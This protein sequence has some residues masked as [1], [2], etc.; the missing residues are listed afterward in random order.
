MFII[1]KTL[2][3]DEI[4]ACKDIMHSILLEH[5]CITCKMDSVWNATCEKADDKNLVNMFDSLCALTYTP[6]EDDREDDYIVATNICAMFWDIAK[7]IVSSAEDF[8]DFAMGCS[9]MRQREMARSIEWSLKD[10]RT[11]IDVLHHIL[12]EKC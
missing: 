10:Y 5:Y 2:T 9:N 6:R 4:R 3:P 12:T 8:I 1:D 7:R 11:M